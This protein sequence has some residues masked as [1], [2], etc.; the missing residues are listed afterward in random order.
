MKDLTEDIEQVIKGVQARK[1]IL[2]TLLEGEPRKGSDLRLALADAFDRRIDGVSDALIYFNLQYLEN[3]GYI[4]SYREWKDKYAQLN[5][6]WVQP[7]RNYFRVVAPVA[8]VGFIGEDPRVHLQLRMKFKLAKGVKPEKFLFFTSTKMRGK[9]SGFFDNV[10]VEF[11]K[12]ENIYDFKY[13][14]KRMDKEIKK[15]ITKYEVIVEVGHGTRFCSLALHQTALEYSLKSF[16]L[17]E[18]DRIFWINE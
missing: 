3:A 2:Q 8:C 9:I 7:L 4:Y 13:L 1:V 12:E 16:Y 11:I 6:E 10:Q 17:T 15:L 18:D 14:I 5:P